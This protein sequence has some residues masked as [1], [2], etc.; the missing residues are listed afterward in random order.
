MSHSFMRRLVGATGAAT[1]G[2]LL[3]AAPVQAAP[4]A[5]AADVKP[6]TAPSAAPTA[7]AA[8][9]KPNTAKPSAA[10]IE[11]NSAAARASLPPDVTMT[12]IGDL[13]ELYGPTDHYS[14]DGPTVTSHY[15]PTVTSHYSQN[16]PTVTSGVTAL[17]AAAVPYNFTFSGVRNLY[18][19]T[20]RLT[21]SSKVC[22]DIKATWDYGYHDRYH[23]F[24]VSLRG[25]S[26]LV[27]ADGI[28]RSYCWS[29]VPTYTDH[30]FRYY[31]SGNSGGH[32]A[33]TSGSGR[34]RYS[35]Q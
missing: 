33:F 9:V 16:G 21:E 22:K 30:Q 23:S 19:R 32:Y 35:W 17:A 31:V 14:Q 10:E 2:L 13:P 1:V 15:G 18:G 34:V 4:T 24:H 3:L 6:N 12:V 11:A 28:A 25:S 7:E 26:V 8:D 29:G 5:E 27:P 20:F